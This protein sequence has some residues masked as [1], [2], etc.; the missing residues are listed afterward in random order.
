VKLVFAFLLLS[1]ACVAQSTSNNTS[2]CSANG[3]PTAGCNGVGS[4]PLLTSGSNTGAQTTVLDPLPTNVSPL[5]VKNYLYSGVTARFIAHYQ[6]WFCNTSNPCNGHLSIGME[7]SNAAQVLEQSESMKSAGF[8]VVNVDYYGC[9]GS[10]GQT[11]SKAYNLSVTVALASAIAANPSVTPKLMIQIDGGAING[12]GAGQCPAAGGDQSGCLISAL[13]AQLDYME[14]TWLAQSYYEHNATNSHQ[15]VPL[16]ITQGDYPGTNFSTVYSAVSAHAAFGNSCG[17][18]CTYANSVDLIDENSG[19][20][21]ESGIAGGFAWPQPQAY[22]ITNQ[23]CWDGNCSNTYLSNFYSVARAHSTKVAIGVLYK[24]FDDSTPGG[25]GSGRVIAQQCGQVFSLTAGAI[26]TA[27]YGIASQLQ[28]IQMATWNDY[29]EGTEI[30]TGVDNCITISAPTISGTTLSWS[31]VKSDATY[32]STSTISSFSIYT[33]TT[34]PTTLFASNISA[35]ATSTTAP[36]LTAG[37]NAWVYM[38]GQPLIQNRISAPVTGGTVSTISDN[39]YC[40]GGTPVWGTSDGP[41]TLPTSCYNTAIANTPATGS[42]VNVSTAGQLTTALAAAA[43]G[44]KITLA[45][46]ASFSGNFTIPSISCPTSNYLWIQSSGVASLPGEGG[47]FTTAYNSVNL[48]VPQFSPCYAGVTSLPGRPLFNCPASA[49][50][51]TAQIVT[52]NTS[53]AL[54]FTAGSSGIRVIGIEITRA[55]ATGLIND[56]VLVGD[57]GVDHVIFDRVWCH[58]TETGDETNRCF[59]DNTASFLA[60]VDSYFSDF[61]CV[62]VS[63][64]CTDSKAIG[65]GTNVTNSTTEST[66]KY[67]NNYLEAAG[68]NMLHGGSS[69]NTIPSNFEIR[70]NLFFKPLTWS[71]IN[72]SYNGG[73]GGHPLVVKNLFEIKNMQLALIEGN[74]FVNTWGGFTQQGQAIT[75]TPV[76]Q[77]GGCSICADQNITLRYNQ[78]NTVNSF[79]DLSLVN[80]GG[81]DA[82]TGN[83]WSI[84]DNVTDNIGYC[85]ANSAS[86][87]SSRS[88]ISNVSDPAITTSGQALHDVLINHNTFVYATGT[89]TR[90]AIG[91][92]GPTI[93]STFN[94]ANF[95]YTNNLQASGS[96]TTNSVGG[97]NPSNCANTGSGSSLLTQCWSPQTFGHNCFVANGTHTWPG[98]N[99]TSVASY[100]AVFSNYNNGN[101]G[102]YLVSPGACQGAASD[103][104]DPGANIAL[105][106]A[107]LAGSPIFPVIPSPPPTPGVGLF[108]RLDK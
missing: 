65:G 61:Y 89:T 23:F 49:G 51:Y 88:T 94:M 50:T 47:R 21:T 83:Q 102:N 42:V 62:S 73:V 68:E 76:N 7:E 71:Q 99:V 6:P 38:V 9:G 39:I 19:A 104:T 75:F 26:S 11:T 95:T 45:A 107:V 92:S 2:A 81:F 74:Q 59:R 24:G 8:D 35:S 29:E 30:E 14:K 36:T 12:S 20:F 90:A 31:L 100:N 13:N 17:T 55:A 80:N 5:S 98:T 57:V 69:S 91:V 25:F 82:A 87:P 16:F 97:S 70:L 48:G 72:P 103:G 78:I 41:A 53:P 15:I 86:C 85:G 54:T 3:T 79:G 40:P 10:C 44:Q 64:S 37:Q 46:G 60:A 28:Y 67:V 84:H 96:G 101:G 106:A 58:G 66:L 52:P 22:S 43:C 56:L 4:M 93:A 34:S 77:S 63:G 33:G 1:V 105:L 18:G 27:G 108:A 32:A